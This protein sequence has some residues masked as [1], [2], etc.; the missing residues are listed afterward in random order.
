MSD[1]YL[2]LLTHLYSTTPSPA[3]PTLLTYLFPATLTL[4]PEHSTLYTQGVGQQMNPTFDEVLRAFQNP[5]IYTHT[6]L[7][8]YTT[9]K[10]KEKVLKE[11]VVT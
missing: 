8:V 5:D 1:L 6:I 10:G 11:Q 9:N 3:H 4:T 2:P 7:R